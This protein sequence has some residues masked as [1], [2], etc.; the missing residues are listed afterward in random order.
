MRKTVLI[1]SFTAVAGLVAASPVQASR[2]ATVQFSGSTQQPAANLPFIGSMEVVDLESGDMSS[3][4]VVTMLLGAV[5]ADG[6]E[7]VTSHE[8]EGDGAPGF[9]FVT[10]DDARLVPTATPGTFSLISHMEIRKGMGAYNCG[11]LVIDGQQSTVSFDTT[12][13]GSASYA[14]FGRLC[15]CKPADN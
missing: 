14:G 10:F 7:I 1:L 9:E 3:A 12:G 2:C 13:L 8:I 6:L 4:S 15:R 5:S 11:E